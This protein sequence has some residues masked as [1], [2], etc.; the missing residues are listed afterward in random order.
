MFRPPEFVWYSSRL[1]LVVRCWG[2][3]QQ[4]RHEVWDTTFHLH[5]GPICVW[6][7]DPKRNSHNPI[8]TTT[9]GAA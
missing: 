6:R 1:H 2:T 7:W 4:A 8:C 9:E 5:L 3:W